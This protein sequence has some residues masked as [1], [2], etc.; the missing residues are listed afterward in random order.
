LLAQV[1]I[2]LE[3]N[4]VEYRPTMI[5]L[6]HVVNI[7]AKELISIV[8]VIPRL[9]DVMLNDGQSNNL[10]QPLDAP[11]AA[12]A[13]GVGLSAEM[14]AADQR[15]QALDKNS[16][17][18]FSIITSDHDT[19]NIVVQ[20]MNGMSAAATE[21]QK[22]QYFW[23]KYKPLW[24]MDKE[25]IIR[26]YAKT[27]R[28]LQQYEAEISRYREQQ[29][30]IEKE[31]ATYSVMF[32]KIDCTLIK[33]ALVDH[34]VQWQNKLTGLLNQNALTELRA[35]HSMFQ[36]NTRKLL[37]APGSLDHLS[38]N[39]GCLKELLREL[40]N[41]EESFAPLEEMYTALKRFDVQVPESEQQ[42]LNGLRGAFDDFKE[43]LS[44]SEKMLE[45]SKQNMKRDLESSLETYNNQVHTISYQLPFLFTSCSG[46]TQD[47]H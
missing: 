25:A 33:K 43:M 12:D 8:S 26:K 4:R 22:Y 9:K 18:F 34:C 1:Y 30:E 11:P 45:K 38:E 13:M 32:I 7:V 10:Q 14:A 3:N 37:V 21:M 27:K 28:T 5:N 47:V 23:D 46:F 44:G 24:E 19:L 42:M 16:G 36:S 20:I 39:I 17:S 35:L 15:A 29:A 2:V 6:T 31:D 41:V 40:P